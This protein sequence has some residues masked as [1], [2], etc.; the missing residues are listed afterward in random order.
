VVAALY[1]PGGEKLL[2]S[3]LLKYPGPE[4][5]SFEV[6]QAGEYRVEVRAEG[7]PT[8]RG[9]Y[10]LT[11]EVKAGADAGDRE[12]QS[13]EELLREAV[14]LERE[15]SKESLSRSVGKYGEAT[16]RWRGVGDR[17]WEAFAL[18]YSG[19]ASWK[20][21]ERQKALEYYNLSLSLNRAVGDRASEANT[22][23]NIG[24]VYNDLG[25]RQKALEYFNLSLPLLRAVG[26]SA[27]ARPT[28]SLT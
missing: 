18:H 6:S 3:D 9:R 15:G 10:E 13:A 4:P 17:F 24:L 27:L 19:R 21:G 5:V 16:G 2:E 25:E 26:D 11:G 12:R 20:L 7:P 14:A 23:N 28:R 22:L 8:A 1:G